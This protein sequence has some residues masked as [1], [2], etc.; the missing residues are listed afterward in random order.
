M[1]DGKLIA[2]SAVSTA[3]GVIFLVIGA[4]FQTFDLSALFMSAIAIMLPLSKNSVKGAL[5]TYFATALLS[6]CFALSRFYVPLLYVL[7]FGIHPI[8]NYIQLNSKK[9]LWYLYILK[10]VWFI[11]VMF[12]MYYSF[13]LFVVE[14][15]FVK[16]FIPIIL[17]LVGAI[18]YIAYDFVM[19]RFQKMSFNLIKRLGL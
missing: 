6:F 2:L 1:K 18:T 7:F 16:R 3:L 5:F 19:I 12:L 11:G 14:V 8:I 4:Y 9:K 17:I 13:T 15:E 10:C